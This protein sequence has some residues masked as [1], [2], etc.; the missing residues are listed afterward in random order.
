VINQSKYEKLSVDLE[1]VE[2]H[3]EAIKK[4]IETKDTL[5]FSDVEAMNVDVTKLMARAANACWE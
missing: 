5:K 1:S 4:I 2:K 3:I